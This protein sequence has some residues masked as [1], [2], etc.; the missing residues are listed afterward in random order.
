MKK[1]VFFGAGNIAQS[2][3]LGLISSGHDKENILFI[4][5]NKKNQSVLKKLGIEEY[6]IDHKDKIDL[7]FLAVKP[8][9]ALV[10]YE[11]ICNS[12]KKPKLYL[13][14]Q[15]SDPKNIFLSQLMWNLLGPCQPPLLDLIKV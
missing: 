2:I 14:L 4:D 9:D 8:K 12:H 15:E 5:R 6:T 7:F 10:A 3:I 1:I 13:W 11:E